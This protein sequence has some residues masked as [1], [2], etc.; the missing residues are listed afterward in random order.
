M[1]DINDMSIAILSALEEIGVTG[2]LAIHMDGD[3]TTALIGSSV[4]HELR[5]AVDVQDLS[6]VQ[7]PMK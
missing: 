2:E 6:A 3:R 5:V 1:A 4:G 7:V